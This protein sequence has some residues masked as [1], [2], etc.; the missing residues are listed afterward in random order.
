MSV[1]P[2]PAGRRPLRSPRP[3]ARRGILHRLGGLP[4]AVAL[5]AVMLLAAASATRWRGAV[6]VLDRGAAPTAERV[7]FV[8]TPTAAPSAVSAAAPAGDRVGGAPARGGAPGRGTAA[9]TDAAVVGASPVARGGA[10]TTP[11]RADTGAAGA[12]AGGV[13]TIAPTARASGRPSVGAT[14]AGAPL[15]GGLGGSVAAARPAPPPL[16]ARQLDSARAQMLRDAARGGIRLLPGPTGDAGRALTGRDYGAL[17]ADQRRDLA[18]AAIE[19]EAALSA[20]PALPPWRRGDAVGLAA[21]QA[22][23]RGLFALEKAGETR[24]RNMDTTTPGVVGRFVERYGGL[25]PG[26]RGLPGGGPTDR[27]RA[28]AILVHEANLAQIRRA[29]ERARRKRDS[30]AAAGADRSATGSA[31]V[32]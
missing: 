32:P 25:L 22:S 31:P 18:R 12:P 16:D 17:G 19:R 2:P 29:E 7:R 13:G 8:P 21:N 26:G 30:L 5:T 14:A 9:A 3:P 11:V 24:R 28:R 10:A 23:W 4:P 15:A 20:M 27:E 6:A 1:A